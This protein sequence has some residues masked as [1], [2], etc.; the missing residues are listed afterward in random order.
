MTAQDSILDFRSDTARHSCQTVLA[1]LSARL[2]IAIIRFMKGRGLCRT[3]LSLFVSLI[4]CI[5]AMA[6]SIGAEPG[7]A[8]NSGCSESSLTQE[9]QG[10]SMVGG[11]SQIDVLEKQIADTT[12]SGGVYFYSE[13]QMRLNGSHVS[14]S[15]WLGKVGK[16]SYGLRDDT[17]DTVFSEEELFSRLQQDMHKSGKPLVVFVHGCCVSFSEGLRQAH[18]IKQALLNEDST[19]PLLEYDWATPYGNYMGSLSR[20]AACRADF[21]AFMDRLV[22]RFGR[23]KIVVIAHSL[24][25]HAL[26][27][28]CYKR[29]GETATSDLGTFPALI[30][31]RPD[32]DSTSFKRCQPALT[33]ASDQLFV[34]CAKNDLNIN[35]SSLIRRTGFNFAQDPTQGGNNSQRLGQVSVAQGFAEDLKVY[36]VSSLGLSHLIPYHF[37]ACLLSGHDKA[38]EIKLL[39]GV[40]RVKSHKT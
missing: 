29:E 16:E 10:S 9:R 28:Y 11:P 20:L 14:A 37:I 26:Q 12:I 5:T 40:Y 22:A 13:R 3:Y 36:D 6:P 35:L 7:A 19:G 17:G 21:N 1:W 34:L 33:K 18:G 2:R 39:G 32:I 8:S 24:G 30:L 4:V 27:D 38:F 23:A 25:I 15:D 31:S